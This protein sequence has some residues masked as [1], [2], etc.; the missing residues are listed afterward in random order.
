MSVFND[1]LP[2]PAFRFEFV[3]QQVGHKFGNGSFV[4]FRMDFFPAFAGR[5][6]ALLWIFLEIPQL[7]EKLEL[8][9]SKVIVTIDHQ[10][11]TSAASIPLALSEC[12]ESGK[13]KK[14]DLVIF[15]SMGAGF[16]WGGALVR[17]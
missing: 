7:V 14:G 1:Y 8:P 5:F 17:I 15:N 9:E 4:I 13:I 11:N 2:R 6:H 3:K 12:L 16:T 10:A